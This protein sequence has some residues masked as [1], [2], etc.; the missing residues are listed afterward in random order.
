MRSATDDSLAVGGRHFHAWQ[1]FTVADAEA[2]AKERGGAAR[3]VGPPA[4]PASAPAL[5]A[6]AE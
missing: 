5:D 1:M 6:A 2:L 3:R 4:P